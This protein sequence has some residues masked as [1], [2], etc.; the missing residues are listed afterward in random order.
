[1]VGKGGAGENT[2]CFG[3]GGDHAAVVQVGFTIEGG[4]RAYSGKQ[5]E[6][7]RGTHCV[8]EARQAER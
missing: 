2:R 3:V 6:G 1:V 8:G 4:L 5:G 7:Q